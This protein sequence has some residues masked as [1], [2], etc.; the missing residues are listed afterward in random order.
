MLRV[1]YSALSLDRIHHRA[2]KAAGQV[3]M[4]HPQRVSYIVKSWK[5]HGEVRASGTG[6]RVRRVRSNEK[7]KAEREEEEEIRSETG[8]VA[9][10]ERDSE[11][12]REDDSDSVLKKK[13][14]V[15]GRTG[16]MA[17]T[18]GKPKIKRSAIRARVGAAAGAIGGGKR[19]RVEK[20][21]TPGG[22]GSGGAEGDSVAKDGLG[23]GSRGAKKPDRLDL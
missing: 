16:S 5:K 14:S 7:E 4:L 1:Y 23:R 3:L 6:R 15:D 19:K 13:Q 9:G 20:D 18:G 11:D 22:C 17:M 12:D 2:A 8:D 10:D 21:E